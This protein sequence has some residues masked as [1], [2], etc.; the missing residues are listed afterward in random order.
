M[1]II[2][3]I[4]IT[5]PGIS[6]ISCHSNKRVTENTPD[7]MLLKNWQPKSV[8]KVPITDIKKARFPV[9]DMHAHDYAKTPEEVAKRVAIMDEAGIEKWLY[10]PMLPEQNLILFIRYIQNTRIGLWSIVGL[11]FPASP[12]KDG[13][14]KPSLNLGDA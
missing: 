11:I 1:K 12:K 3:F 14:K 2:L 10:L 7:Q 4:L 5:F 6:M 9:I 13:V 8:Y